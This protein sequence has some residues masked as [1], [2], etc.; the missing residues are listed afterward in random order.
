MTKYQ[1]TH[2]VV[3][4]G[5]AN[6]K[7]LPSMHGMPFTCDLRHHTPRCLLEI[8]DRG[9][10]LPAALDGLYLEPELMTRLPRA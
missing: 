4:V 2:V 3:L 9:S 7:C 5:L 8:D 6:A 1:T 10:L